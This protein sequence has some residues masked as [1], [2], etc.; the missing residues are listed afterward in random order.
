[1]SAAELCETIRTAYD[2]AAQA[3]FDDARANGTVAEVAWQDVGPVAADAAF[4]S[5]RHDSGCSITWAMNEAPRGNVPSD[6]LARLLRPHPE[7]DRK[8]VTLLY[9]P[10]DSAKAARI[11][12][13]DHRDAEATVRNAKRPTSRMLSERKSAAA[14]AS[15]E[16]HGA[17]LL[18]FGLLITA[19]APDPD[20]LDAAKRAVE[21]LAPSARI[22]IRPAYGY[23]EAAFAAALPLGVVLPAH[24]QTTRIKE[25]L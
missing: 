22:R 25:G 1:M 15:E 21:Q 3:T 18:S 4:G 23:Q 13:S 16:A 6:I 19:T 7:I 14:T 8:R 2:P 10:L 20:R 11:V 12:E 24:Q 17:G 9:R 5:Y